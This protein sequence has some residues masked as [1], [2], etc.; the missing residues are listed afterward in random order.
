[1]RVSLFLWVSM[2]I[3]L[4]L[5]AFD[6]NG[7]SID[8]IEVTLEF[9][10]ATLADVLTKIQSET[11]INFVYTPDQV[12]AINNINLA[13]QRRTVKNLLETVLVETSITYKEVDGTVVLFKKK[14]LT[15][16]TQEMT[17]A[18]PDMA[19]EYLVTGKITD[20][21][22][23]EILPAVNVIVKGTGNGTSSDKNG[24]Y[25]ISVQNDDDILVF[26]F[27]GFKSYEIAAGGRSRIDVALESDLQ[28]LKEVVINAGYYDVTDKEK[29]GSISKVT[30]KVIE[31]QPV[32]NPLLALQGRV[33]GV[34]I[35][36]RSGLPGSKI[37][38]NIRG[39]NSLQNGTE[40]F[41]VV[42]GVPYSSQNI[43]G[44]NSSTLY[45][46]TGISP[47]YSINPADIESVEILKDADATAIYGSRG[48]NGVIL[49]TTKKG[50]QGKAKIGLNF[51]SGISKV[52][53]FLDLMNSEAYL[54]MRH[55]A[56]RNDNRAI[57]PAHYDINGV[58][59]TTR[60]TNWQKEFLGGTARN[61]IA[62]ASISGGTQATTYLFSGS[63]QKET[64]VFPFTNST[65]KGSFLF[66][67]AN[68]SPNERLKS[69]FSTN[70]VINSSDLNGSDLTGPAMTLAPVAPKLYNEDGSLNWENSTWTNPLASSKYRRFEF[71]SYNLISNIS[72]AY[73]I[74]EGLE[75]KS[76]FGLNHL[77]R[78]EKNV[79]PSTVRNPAT[80]PT[81]ASS[82]V[83]ASNS[84]NRTW[85]FEP[86]ISWMSKEFV[87]GKL[88]AI[89]GSTFQN[90]N[91]NRKSFLYSG[92]SSN[93][94][95]DDLGAAANVANEGTDIST[96]R[97]EA[98]YS[99][100]NYSFHDKYILNLTGR[101]DGSSRFGPGKRFANLGAIGAAW[102][103]SNENFMKGV[104]VMNFGK[105]RSS[106]GV[107]GN[108]Q[109]GD[110]RFLDTYTSYSPYNGVG[111]LVPTKLYNPN[112][113]WETTRKFEVALE[114]GFLNDRM[115]LTSAYYNNQSSNQLVDY[116]VGSTTGFTGVLKNFPA[117]IENSG[118]EIEI[119]SVNTIN[120][121][122]WAT[123]FNI[124]FP[125]NRLVEFKGLES[126]SYASTY[127]VGKS[128]NISK[129]YN[130]TGIDPTTG[131]YTF[132]DMNND[133]EITSADRLVVREMNT[134]FFGGINNSFSFKGWT[135]DIFFQFVNKNAPSV[136]GIFVTPGRAFNQPTFVSNNGWTG[137]GDDSEFQRFS[138]NN[139]NT[140]TAYERF[141]GSEK[142][143]VDAS[144]I[145]LKN[146]S[147]SYRFPK[148]WT[149][150][151]EST[152]FIQGQNIFT[153][154]G[155]DG[156][157]PET[158]PGYSL[159]TLRTIVF[160]ANITL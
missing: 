107:T 157:D 92:F 45:S 54:E 96:Y 64:T 101:R 51:S 26:S 125:R 78:D 122:K 132:E 95:I 48:A 155:Y 117:K 87:F 73:E 65:Q 46:T 156:L 82:R 17:E 34:F 40:P 104:S 146:I 105:L 152:L 44:V 77:N 151:V 31:K 70:Y 67:I 42:D 74:V 106:F 99:R 93:A 83:F 86:Q 142:G 119:N 56:F 134:K 97:Y 14:K 159:P 114:L 30:S 25:S 20:S 43:G 100:I 136:Y 63:Y 154:T 116:R 71:A 121:F 140:A 35:E 55:Q 138:T 16:E 133:G 9:K 75:I 15:G 37:N 120:E 85:I 28:E 23:G 135:L 98:A 123:S 36:Q 102:I 127:V 22:T 57:G 130:Y 12:D 61:T 158:G 8:Q 18:L 69:R 143:I 149:A 111:G 72:L 115:N 148:S 94:L 4:Q 112:Y 141:A 52:P 91:I 88:S 129:R 113:A 38:I 150:G 90:Q 62:Q 84:Y 6:T 153:I 118:L 32:N 147:L 139:S 7:Q 109:I 21:K 66:S 128:L 3:S 27:I 126:S 47:F 131:I 108:D 50:K 49:I 19:T 1:M 137:E 33:P 124:S 76:N 145:R 2:A 89:I 79:D 144:F 39:K 24:V 5:A 160:G 10:N 80:N 68:E 81:P 13:R 53:H 60:Y 110:Y 11:K 58:W 41:Y 59:D 103:F 29:T